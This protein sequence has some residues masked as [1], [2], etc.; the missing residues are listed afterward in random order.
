MA[1]KII[2]KE[3]ITQELEIPE[4]ELDEYKEA[5]ALFDKDGDG[6][7]STK[8]FIKV[9][10]NLGQNVSAEEAKNI[11]QELDQDNSGMIDFPEFVSYM[12]KTKVIEEVDDEDAVIKAFMTFDKDKKG[13]ITCQ[14]F[15]YI[16][17][18]LGDRF[19]QEECD[20]VFKE[21]GLDNNGILDYRKFVEEWR[22]R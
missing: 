16:L 10:K 12:K 2:E 13:T 22:N 4:E 3:V 20:E 18:N 7:I 19:T 14:E 1:K 8:E 11:M 5:F 21:A 17:C 6:Q 15:R 9:L